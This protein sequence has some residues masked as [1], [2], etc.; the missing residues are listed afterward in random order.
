MA[1]PLAGSGTRPPDA[2]A[3]G[4]RF[5]QLAG[6]HGVSCIRQRGAQMAAVRGTAGQAQVLVGQGEIALCVTG[7]DGGDGTT[8]R[9]GRI[10]QAHAA[11]MAIH[12]G[13]KQQDRVDGGQRDGNA[14]RRP[15]RVAR[16]H[17]ACCVR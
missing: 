14:R 11:G 13:S 8:Q 4:G 16:W 17:V 1:S 9:V 7:F 5:A 3:Q 12:G 10:T 6:Q 15:V 2:A